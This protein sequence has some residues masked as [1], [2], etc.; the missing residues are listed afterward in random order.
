MTDIQT[1]KELKKTIAEKETSYDTQFAEFNDMLLKVP[2]P[3]LADVPRGGE[4]DNQ[5]I[6]LVGE[7]R[8]F[9]FEAK[10]HW[11]ILEAKGYLDSERAVKMSGSRFVMVK[12]K[13]AELQFALTQWAMQ[14]LIKK[15]FTPCLVP[16]M[17]KE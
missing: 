11:E 7:K 2:N 9:D 3:P 1:V 16:F 4:E 13:L 6:K 8:E 17:V 14:K 15:G 10:P 12:G 5:V